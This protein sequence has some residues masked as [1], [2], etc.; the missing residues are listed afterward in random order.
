MRTSIIGL[1]IVVA[2]FWSA[3]S[4]AQSASKTPSLAEITLRAE[5]QSSLL[6][7][8]DMQV[9]KPIPVI[10]PLRFEEIPVGPGTR[11][12]EKPCTVPHKSA[13]DMETQQGNEPG[14]V[15]PRMN[16]AR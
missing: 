1:T 3:A 2:T 8:S 15:V 14:L 7:R 5:S 4:H 12:G 10:R 13:V 11:G 6:A 16:I 9:P